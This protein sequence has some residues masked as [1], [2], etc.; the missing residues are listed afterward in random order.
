MFYEDAHNNESP[1]NYKE[2]FLG[3]LPDDPPLLSELGIDLA[4]IKDEASL[5]IRVF[6]TSSFVTSS[7]LTGPITILLA[8][9][10]SLVLQGKLHFEYIY[11]ISLSSTLFIY[12]VTNL[13]SAKPLP[14]A[15]CSNVMFYSF[16]PILLFSFLNIVFRFLPRWMRLLAGFGTTLW[17][18]YT[19]SYVFCCNLQQS[20]KLVVL[21]Y[22]LLL[23]YLCFIMMIIF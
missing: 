5:P 21:A 20:N 14:F 6:N 1:C 8:F 11:L 18:C 9:T 23:T 15:V 12:V 2:A 4:A 22:P 10:L 7:D 3:S 13:I 16:S 17:S 19:A